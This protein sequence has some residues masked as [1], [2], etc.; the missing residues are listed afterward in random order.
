MVRKIEKSLAHGN[1]GINFKSLENA[2]NSLNEDF[3]YI[4]IKKGSL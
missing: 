2:I 3:K 4:S 1:M